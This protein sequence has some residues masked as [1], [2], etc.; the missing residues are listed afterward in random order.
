MGAL[1]SCEG[2]DSNRLKHVGAISKR[3]AALRAND[4]KRR[5]IFRKFESLL[6]DVRRRWPK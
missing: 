3:H 5:R 6:L 1:S 4:A 2:R